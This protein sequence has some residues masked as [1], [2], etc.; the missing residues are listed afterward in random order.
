MCSPLCSGGAGMANKS[1]YKQPLVNG[2]LN[3]TSLNPLYSTT[4]YTLYTVQFY[5]LLYKFVYLMNWSSSNEWGF[6]EK[7]KMHG[8]VDPKIFI[9][10]ICLSQHWS[11][12]YQYLKEWIRGRGRKGH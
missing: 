11:S 5:I 2:Y 7:L 10:T 9:F 1:L 8:G 12:D 4:V 3:V 6:E